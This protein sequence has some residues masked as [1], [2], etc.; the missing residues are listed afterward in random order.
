M[1]DQASE[2]TKKSLLTGI[3]NLGIPDYNHYGNLVN[4]GQLG[5]GYQPDY[6][7]AATPLVFPPVVLVVLQTPTMYSKNTKMGQMIKSV[8]ET[9]PKSVSGLDIGYT[10][11]TQTAP[12]GHDGQEQEVPMSTKRSAPSPSFTFQEVHGN[13]IWNLFKKWI[14]DM[15]NPDTY[16]AMNNAAGGVD[17]QPYTMSSYAMSM[18]AIQFDST[19]LPDN[20]IDGVFYT[21]MFPKETGDLGIERQIGT[22]NLRERS[23]PF[24]AIAQ[25]NKFTKALAKKVAQDLQLAKVNY[26]RM[27]TGITEV[28]SSLKESGLALGAKQAAEA[29]KTEIPGLK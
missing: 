22:T 14:W 23:I 11:D 27:K 5:I 21:N 19:F 4:G 28:S 17:V 12:A 25:H 1:A 3:E 24:S 16:T 10:V 8:I 6:L 26:A 13:L 15:H 2:N 7:D 20:I 29:S 9:H 18:I